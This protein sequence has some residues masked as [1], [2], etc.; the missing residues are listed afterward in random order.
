MTHMVELADKIGGGN[1]RRLGC[2]QSHSPK[3]WEKMTMAMSSV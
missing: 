1:Y 3:T 2:R